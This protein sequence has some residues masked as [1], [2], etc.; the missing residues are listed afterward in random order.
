MNFSKKIDFFDF[1]QFFLLCFVSHTQKNLGYLTPFEHSV[2]PVTITC[3]FPS[4]LL[5]SLAIRWPP[6]RGTFLW[7]TGHILLRPGSGAGQQWG[8]PLM[9]QSWSGTF[10]GRYTRLTRSSPGNSMVLQRGQA[11]RSPFFAASFLF[12]LRLSLSR[13]AL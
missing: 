13:S 1:F 12:C 4:V 2:Q 10:M 8:H 11:T 3:F 7:H 9:V 5:K 6:L